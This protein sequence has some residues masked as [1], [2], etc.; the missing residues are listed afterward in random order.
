MPEAA[1]SEARRLE[2]I[3]VEFFDRENEVGVPKAVQEIAEALSKAEQGRD[4]AW[5]AHDFQMRRA[6]TAEQ[7]RKDALQGL[8]LSMERRHELE[9]QVRDLREALELFPT[10]EFTDE[11]TKALAP[12]VFARHDALQATQEDWIPD[13]GDKPGVQHFRSQS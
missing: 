13:S 12:F 11:Q 9:A 8:M 5:Q 2:Q 6:E 10:V 7:E 4:E 3:V 1:E